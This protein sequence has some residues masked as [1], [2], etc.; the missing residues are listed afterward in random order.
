VQS[1]R[2]WGESGSGKT[3]SGEAYPEIGFANGRKYSFRVMIFNR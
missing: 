1:L 3:N 2:W